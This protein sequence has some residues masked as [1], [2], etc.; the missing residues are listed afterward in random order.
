M[1]GLVVVSH[2]ENAADGI[3][4]IAEEMGSGDA[5][6]VGV[7]GDPDGGIGTDLDAIVRVLDAMADEDGVVLLVDLG[8]AV[9]QAEI[10][11]EETDVDAVIADGPVLEGAVN[12]A[13]AATSPKADVESVRE[14]AEAAGEI[15]KL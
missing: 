1:V 11:I 15:S 8:S 9:M 6:L 12:A 3:V 7:G 13:V 2:S 4:E 14:A 5:P 10:A